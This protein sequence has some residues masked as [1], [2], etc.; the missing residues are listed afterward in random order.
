[1]LFIFFGLHQD[2]AVYLHVISEFVD[3]FLDMSILSIILSG[4][5]FSFFFMYFLS[6]FAPEYVEDEDGFLVPKSNY[7]T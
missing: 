2:N 5:W 4:F 6:I 1:M 3:V 7:L